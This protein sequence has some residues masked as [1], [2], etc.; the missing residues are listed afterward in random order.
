M[1]GEDLDV[2]G[3]A[4]EAIADRFEL[5]PRARLLGLP[6]VLRITKQQIGSADV[7]DKQG[8]A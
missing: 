7:A 2:P 1:V 5:K 3:Q 4:E 6:G 8:V